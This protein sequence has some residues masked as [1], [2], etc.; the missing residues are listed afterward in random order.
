MTIG[1][2]KL[3]QF[4]VIILSVL[5]NLIRFWEYRFKYEQVE[6]VD[7]ELY[8]TLLRLNSHYFAIYYTALYL[9]THFLLPFLIILILNVYVV[10]AIKHASEERR[11]LSSAQIQQHRTTRMIII[12][13]IMFALC[14]VITFFLNIWESCNPDLFNADSSWSGTAFVLLD[15]SNISIMINSSVNFVVYLIYCRRYRILFLFYNKRLLLCTSTKSDPSF[16]TSQSS[17]VSGKNYTY[18]KSSITC[19]GNETAI[20]DKWNNLID[21]RKNSSEV[22]L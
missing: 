9:L 4:V 1:R 16:I 13:T 15:V 11:R 19:N 17:Y 18:T 22:N 2:T 10:G 3:T 8:E 5:Y 6:E 21:N 7:G 12:V 20:T 14:N